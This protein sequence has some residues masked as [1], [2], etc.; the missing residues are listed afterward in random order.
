MI[1]LQA[2]L[3]PLIAA[4]DAEI[5]RLQGIIDSTGS[6]DPEVARL[7]GIIDSIAPGELGVSTGRA[8]VPWDKLGYR[9]HPLDLSGYVETFRHDCTTLPTD[10]T[11]S[12]PLY[13]PVHTDFG[14]VHFRKLSENTGTYSIVNGRLRIR[15]EPY[16][17]TLGTQTWT[18]ATYPGDPVAVTGGWL[19]NGVTTAAKP[20]ITRKWQSGHISTLT[21]AGVGFHQSMGAFQ[22]VYSLPSGGTLNGAPGYWGGGWL[23][24]ANEFIPSIGGAMTEIDLQENYGGDAKAVHST[25]HKKSKLHPDPGDYLQSGQRETLSNYAD[26]KGMKYTDNPTQSM[27]PGTSWNPM[28]DNQ[29]TITG[30]MDDDWWTIYWDGLSICRYPMLD[31]WKT[32]QYMNFSSIMQ[33]NMGNV[34]PSA[35]QDAY[36]SLVRA[37][38]RV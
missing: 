6:S 9:G 26:L 10:E 1:D 35:P 27:F 29:H 7:Q 12:G 30:I 23:L 31:I 37:L 14:N 4:K 19:F 25:V 18:Q 24:S 15:M 5:A 28:D 36:I 34:V 8:V 2:R 11:G 17:W 38:R 21:R 3:N 22:Y 13:A 33:D 16:Q 32:P 20:A